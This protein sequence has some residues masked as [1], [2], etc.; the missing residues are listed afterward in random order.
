MLFY[1]TNLTKLAALGLLRKSNEGGAT[2]DNDRNFARGSPTELFLYLISLVG[3][4]SVPLTEDN[5]QNFARGSP[6]YLSYFSPPGSLHNHSQLLL[7]L[8]KIRTLTEGGQQLNSKN[9]TDK[10]RVLICRQVWITC[11]I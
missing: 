1:H 3:V 5:K 2:E 4:V 7:V 11:L 9:D 6:T 8:Q 10:G